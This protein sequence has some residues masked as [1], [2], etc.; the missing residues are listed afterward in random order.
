MEETKNKNVKKIILGIVAVVVIAGLAGCFVFAYNKVKLDSSQSN[1]ITTNTS[2]S[3]NTSSK[4]TSSSSVEEASNS[5]ILNITKGGT[6]DLSGEYEEIVVNTSE[7]VTLNLNGV[8]IT[9]SRGP[10]INI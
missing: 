8:E 4:T 2:D 1:T 5:K 3:I 10:A 6:Y 7:E 9:N